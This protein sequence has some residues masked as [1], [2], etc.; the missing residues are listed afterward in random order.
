MLKNAVEAGVNHVEFVSYDGRYPNF[1]SGELVLVIN[2]MTHYFGN[3]YYDHQDETHHKAFWSKNW[4]DMEGEW[5]IDCLELPEF[6]RPYAHEID[7]TFNA[8]VARRCCG[9]CR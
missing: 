6:L 3:H 7:C 8:N 4:L 5:E 2:G 9:G 1:C